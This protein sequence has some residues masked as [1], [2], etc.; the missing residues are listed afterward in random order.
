VAQTFA[1]SHRT[2]MRQKRL[3][4]NPRTL[5]RVEQT[6]DLAEHAVVADASG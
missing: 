5:V 1:G 3:G 6:L 2:F 4:Q